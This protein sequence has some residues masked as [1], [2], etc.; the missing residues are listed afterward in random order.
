MQSCLAY[1]VHIAFAVSGSY[2]HMS[3]INLLK[4]SG[5]STR[6]FKP[7]LYVLPRVVLQNLQFWSGVFCARCFY[8]FRLQYTF[9][10]YLSEKLQRLINMLFGNIYIVQTLHSCTSRT[11]VCQCLLV[12]TSTDNVS[13][14]QYQRSHLIATNFKDKITK[15]CSVKG[16][17]HLLAGLISPEQQ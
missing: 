11:G 7:H 16:V 6:C 12:Q 8:I 3:D 13:K 1:S 14:S 10:R 15:L 5:L 2:L 17:V 4:H 9:G